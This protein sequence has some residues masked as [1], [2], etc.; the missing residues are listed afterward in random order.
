[1]DSLRPLIPEC[2]VVRRIV[3]LSTLTPGR[4]FTL[5]E[6]IASFDEDEPGDRLAASRS[7]LTPE[8]AWKYLQI[9]DGEVEAENALLDVR[10][11]PTTT[12]VSELPRQGWDRLA[13]RVRG[14]VE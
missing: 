4:C 3:L 6:P 7:I 12:K 2:F 1:M 13:E 8:M 11:F 9:V 5:V 14:E 10:R